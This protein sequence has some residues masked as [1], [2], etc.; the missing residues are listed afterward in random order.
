MK[1]IYNA[2]TARLKEKVP[3][4]R[5]IDFDKGQLDSMD[6]PAVAFPCALLTIS[7]SN[8]RNITRSRARMHRPRARDASR[9]TGR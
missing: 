2:I 8:A 3:A 4:I 7:V 1:T 6:R 9:S 5:W